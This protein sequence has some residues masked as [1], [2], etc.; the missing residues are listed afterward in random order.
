MK[1][2]SLHIRELITKLSKEKEKKEVKK[3][4]LGK[5]N[6]NVSRSKEI[7][8]KRRKLF[9]RRSKINSLKSILLYAKLIKII[10]FRIQ[11]SCG[12]KL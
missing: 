3:S 6:K 8:Q 12:K 10:F 5:S 11:E 4:K 2:R 7:L 1:T 9:A